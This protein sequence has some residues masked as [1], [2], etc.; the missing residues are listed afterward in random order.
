MHPTDWRFMKKGLVVFSFALRADALEPNPCNVRLAKAVERIVAEEDDDVVIVAQ[1]EVARQLRR[2]N[3]HP[4]HAVEL[5]LNGDYLGSEQVWEEA[6]TLFKELGISEIIPVGNPF[7]HM[8]KLQRMLA[9]DGYTV[10][11]RPI[12]W[13]GF[14]PSPENTQWWCKGP[15]RLVIYAVLQKL[16]AQHG[17]GGKQQA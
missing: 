9:A 11:K 5:R 8:Y 7:L 2:D 14:D 4:A 13:I 17:Y 1:W 3:L 16:F 15:V 6:K 10:I 12:G